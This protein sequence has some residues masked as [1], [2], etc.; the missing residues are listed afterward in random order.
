MNSSTVLL[1][2]QWLLFGSFLI[3]IVEVIAAFTGATW[4]HVAYTQTPGKFTQ[5][6]I[7]ITTVGKEPELV[8]MTIDKL[9]EYRLHISF[10]IWV[11]VEPGHFIDY[12]DAEVFVVPEGFS[13]RPIDKARAL[14]YSR[15]VRKSRHLNTSA[16]KILFVDDDTLPSASYIGKAFNGDYDLCQ[17]ITVPSRWYGTGNWKHLFISHLD[18]IRTRNCLIYCSCTQGMSQKPLFVHGEGLCITGRA[19]DIVTWDRP[20]V[21]S[22]D[23]VFGTNAAHIGLTWGYFYAAIQLVSPWSWKE[24]L[25]QRWRWTWGNFDAIA[26]RDILPRAYAYFIALR[27]AAGLASVIASSIGSALLL[28]GVARV[29]PQAHKVFLI[30]S[31]CQFLSYGV[32]GWINSGGQPNRELRATAAK[33][34]LFRLVQTIFAIAF[35]PVNAIIPMCVVVYCALRGRPKRF[36]VIKKSNQIMVR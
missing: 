21:A 13:C 33:Y 26:R 17:G 30:S 5:M 25:D 4:S 11:V 12:T 34:W 35:T 27:Y 2:F 9:R 1:V 29:P 10:E 16:V 18:D 24:F 22:D 19:E 20:I 3:P 7:Q 6:I 14:E 15:L 28:T 32:A 8:Q 36:M 31:A 23:L